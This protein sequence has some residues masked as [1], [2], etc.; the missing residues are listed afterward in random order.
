MVCK[1]KGTIVLSSG[2][3]EHVVFIQ[4]IVMMSPIRYRDKGDPLSQVTLVNGDQI[5]CRQ[6]LNEICNLICQA[7]P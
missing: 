5:L 3:A 7:E 4:H 1:V 2:N 6:S